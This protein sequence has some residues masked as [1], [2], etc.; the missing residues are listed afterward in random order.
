MDGK[1]VVKN[2][3]TQRESFTELL[4]QLAGKTAA[5]VH[6]EM[7][8]IIQRIREKTRAVRNGALMIAMGAIIGFA[9]FLSLCASCIIGL[10]FYM[11]PVIAALVT[12]A[13]LAL[14]SVIIALIG[15]SQLKKK[16]PKT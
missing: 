6:D 9:A 1:M 4:G 5:V 14:I 2:P 7:E 8:L 13:T 15:Y 12:G 10:T 11:A 16:T 3:T